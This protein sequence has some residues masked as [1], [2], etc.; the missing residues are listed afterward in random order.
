[1]AADVRLHRMRLVAANSGESESARDLELARALIA[2][3]SLAPEL[4]WERYAPLVQAFL[5]R[6]RR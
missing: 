2:G 3:D 5:G 4:A 1:M 6:R